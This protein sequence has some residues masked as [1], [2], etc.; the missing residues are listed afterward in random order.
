MVGSYNAVTMGNHEEDDGGF[1][2]LVPCG[3]GEEALPGQ[4]ISRKYDCEADCEAVL[5]AQESFVSCVEGVSQQH[6]YDQR[7]S[8]PLVLDTVEPDEG[9]MIRLTA[10][11][12]DQQKRHVVTPSTTSTMPELD[13]LNINLCGTD[14]EDLDDQRIRSRRVVS[15]IGDSNDPAE[16]EESNGQQ[17]TSSSSSDPLT[18]TKESSENATVTRDMN[19]APQELQVQSTVDSECCIL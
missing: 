15:P 2:D 6:E 3:S 9:A 10:M 11:E 13:L 18:S 4:Q 19:E 5:E 17:S 12:Q 7:T 1:A 8:K 16:N 14:S